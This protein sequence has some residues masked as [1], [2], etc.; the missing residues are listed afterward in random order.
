MDRETTP[1]F[2]LWTALQ[3]CPAHLKPWR[4]CWNQSYFNTDIRL[5]QGQ[6]R[7]IYY[8]RCTE[9]ITEWDFYR[10]KHP[11]RSV[12]EITQMSPIVVLCQ[13]DLVK[14]YFALAVWFW[15]VFGWV[16]SVGMTQSH[17]FLGTKYS[18][19]HGAFALALYVMFDKLFLFAVNNPLKLQRSRTWR[20]SMLH[21]YLQFISHM[22]FWF[23]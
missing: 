1:C 21:R 10:G 15:T 5:K 23:Y 4:G 8:I 3:V 9:C 6:H 7:D 20:G 19:F 11:T 14:N 22:S 17:I 18:A 13:T 12:S 2:L 16:T